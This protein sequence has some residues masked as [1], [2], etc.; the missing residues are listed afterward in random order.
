[1]CDVL[2][3]VHVEW[4][5][6]S[7]LSLRV[8]LNELVRWCLRKSSFVINIVIYLRSIWIGY[9]VLLLNNPGASVS[10]CYLNQPLMTLRALWSLKLL[11]CLMSQDSMTLH[12]IDRFTEHY[13]RIKHLGDSSSLTSWHR[14]K[15]HILRDLQ[16]PIQNT[17]KLSSDIGIAWLVLVVQTF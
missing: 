9:L 11:V 14:R 2:L 12:C 10:S 8:L 13:L 6:L 7:S 17:L 1:M 16:V 3:E 15:R 5:R 4:I